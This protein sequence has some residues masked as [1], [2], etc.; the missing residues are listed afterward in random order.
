V[1]ELNQAAAELPI[2]N[3]LRHGLLECNMLGV[4]FKPEF[5][6]YKRVIVVCAYNQAL[7]GF[8]LPTI[9]SD[10]AHLKGLN[11]YLKV[12]TVQL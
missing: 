1:T 7:F 9:K 4:D 11:S 5:I 3:Y 12:K 10:G 6:E 2:F 8:L